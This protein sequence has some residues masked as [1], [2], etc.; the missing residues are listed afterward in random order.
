MSIIYDA[1]RYAGIGPQYR[2]YRYLALA[3]G[4]VMKYGWDDIQITKTV[5]PEIAER[6]NT[7]WRSVERDIRTAIQR[8]WE[9]GGQEIMGRIIGR[10]L[11]QRPTNRQ[12]I[13]AMAEELSKA[14]AESS[15]GVL[16]VQFM[17]ED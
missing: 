11:E 10:Q 15:V 9:S 3:V 6:Y 5:Y 8:A 1:L 2:G 16:Y 12:F 4:L 17:A 7:A 14:A 13:C